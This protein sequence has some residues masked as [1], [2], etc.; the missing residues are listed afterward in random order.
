MFIRNYV[1]K[2]SST[3]FL[4]VRIN[5]LEDFKKM[6]DVLKEKFQANEVQMVEN[7]ERIKET[8]EIINR[9]I[10]FDKEMY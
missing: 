5:V 2:K 6:Q 4:D 10:E 9:K 3:I 7:E 8:M 1:S